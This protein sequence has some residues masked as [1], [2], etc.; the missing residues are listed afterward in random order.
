[1]STVQAAAID[2]RAL[3]QAVRADLWRHDFRFWEFR[4][5]DVIL[6][7]SYGAG[8]P[9][10]QIARRS[11]FEELIGLRSDHVLRECESLE[12]KRVIVARI[13][14]D[15]VYEIVPDAA[16]W[17][18][19]ELRQ[20]TAAASAEAHGLILGGVRAPDR[21]EDL[22][23]DEGARFEGAVAEC[24]REFRAAS[25]GAAAQT[26]MDRAGGVPAGPGYA[27]NRAGG[28]P[29][30]SVLAGRASSQIPEFGNGEGLTAG[31]FPESGNSA[32]G[33]K[34]DGRSALPDSGICAAVLPDSGKGN[35]VQRLN[36]SSKNNVSNVVT[37]QAPDSGPK[38]LS[39]QAER[40]LI[41]RV[42]KFVGDKDWAYWG[43]A[44]ITHGVRKA[45]AILE[46][47]I[48]D[49]ESKR[50]EG[51]RIYDPARYLWSIFQLFGGER[52][53]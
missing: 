35:V 36:V 12:G 13:W 2:W 34:G 8:R 22:A 17:K 1:M 27:G 18:V 10:A 37:F 44:W 11:L 52:P 39:A 16:G 45:P 43:G 4:V 9:A 20:A 46:R 25:L 14:R 21:R 38:R 28:V 47:A 51:K 48:A 26:K 5:L 49:V 23:P 32:H 29:A 15:G 53:K 7:F 31:A 41:A 3:E 6:R 19:T 40:E 33:M 50:R 42:R 24:A 30:G